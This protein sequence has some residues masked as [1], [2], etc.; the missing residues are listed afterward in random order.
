MSSS[1]QSSPSESDECSIPDVH[2]LQRYDQQPEIASNDVST[3]TS[4]ETSAAVTVK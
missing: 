3:T 1:E 4:D 2:K